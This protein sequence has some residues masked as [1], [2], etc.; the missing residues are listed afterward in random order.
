M[1]LSTVQPFPWPLRSLRP[2]DGLL[3]FPLPCLVNLGAPGVCSRFSAA[4]P[5]L[6]LTAMAKITIHGQYKRT[7]ELQAIPLP[8]GSLPDLALLA[9]LD[10]IHPKQVR[11]LEHQQAVSSRSQQGACCGHR[12]QPCL[13]PHLW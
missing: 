1:R 13:V 5:P 11:P 7:K 4:L 3:L 6:L 10:G 8:T 2:C 12:G 9:S